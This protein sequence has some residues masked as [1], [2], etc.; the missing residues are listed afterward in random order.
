MATHFFFH[1]KHCI[2]FCITAYDGNILI[3]TIVVYRTGVSGDDFWQVAKTGDGRAAILFGKRP[4]QVLL[5]A[6]SQHRCSV[7]RADARKV[8]LCC[9]GIFDW[10]D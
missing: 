4:A 2:Q 9:V 1:F 10:K 8:C 6:G 3:A 5:L 7:D